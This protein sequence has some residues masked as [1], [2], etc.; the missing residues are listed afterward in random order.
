MET[1]EFKCQINPDVP[2]KNT[3]R[4]YS[5]HHVKLMTEWLDKYIEEKQCIIEVMSVGELRDSTSLFN[6]TTLHLDN[7]RGMI[8]SY[9]VDDNGILTVNIRPIVDNLLNVYAED[10]ELHTLFIASLDEEKKVS[11]EDASFIYFYLD[12]NPNIST[13]D[14]VSKMSQ[15]KTT[16][17]QPSVTLLNALHGLRK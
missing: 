12:F 1:F 11:E 4:V 2:N 16:T 10:L 6:D 3:G 15:V 7:V 8:E 17:G 5:R 14:I 13:G 9:S